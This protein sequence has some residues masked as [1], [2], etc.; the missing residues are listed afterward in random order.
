MA[1]YEIPKYES[2]SE[3]FADGIFLNHLNLLFQLI[4]TQSEHTALTFGPCCVPRS[5]DQ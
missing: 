3:G 5:A 4:R 1:V 2:A